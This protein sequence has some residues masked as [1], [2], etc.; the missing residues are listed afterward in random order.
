MVKRIAL[1][2][3]GMFGDGIEFA[4]RRR[5][6]LFHQHVKAG[7]QRI[8]GDVEARL[9]RHA[10]RHRIELQSGGEKF[11]RGLEAWHLP[12][13][14]ARGDDGGQFEVAVLGNDRQ[15]LVLGDLAETDDGE[16]EGHG[17]PQF[18]L[19]WRVSE[20]SRASTSASVL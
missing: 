8:A 20:E 14:A 13:G 2:A 10:E 15:V 4:D 19:I 1:A 18:D 7:V 6:R 9:R 12:V 16:L 3:L 17:R 5:R 11:G